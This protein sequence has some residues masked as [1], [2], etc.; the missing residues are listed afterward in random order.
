MLLD[1]DIIPGVL[2]CS[3]PAAGVLSDPPLFSGHAADGCG[4]RCH[5]RQRDTPV[6]PRG[7][8]RV[9]GLG[10]GLGR[11][12]HRGEIIRNKLKAVVKHLRQSSF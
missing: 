4:S 5:H 3:L 10:E 2:S 6:Q 12:L 11:L 7:A 9:A 8:E 1:L